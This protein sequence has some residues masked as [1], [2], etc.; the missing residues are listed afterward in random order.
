MSYIE[1]DFPIERLNEIALKE[2]NAKKPIYQI[3]KWWARRLGSIFRMI[4]LATFLPQ[5]ISED[6]LWK[7]FYSRTDLGDKI[8]LDPFMGGGTTI[9]EALK[10]GCKVIGVDIHPVA[11]FVTKKEVEP[12]DIEEFKREIEAQARKEAREIIEKAKKEAERIIEGAREELK[13][14]LERAREEAERDVE[15]VTSKLRELLS[16]HGGRVYE[17]GSDEF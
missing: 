16:R 4:I 1:K 13:K 9:V 10:L 11:W 12:L 6:E 5:D 14:A 17:V 8:I 3:H 7:R 15:R 2:A